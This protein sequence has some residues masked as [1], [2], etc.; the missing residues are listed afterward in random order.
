MFLCFIYTADA[1]YWKVFA[2][3]A[4]LTAVTVEGVQMYF[5]HKIPT[6]W[7]RKNLNGKSPERS[8][9]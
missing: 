2:F 3:S 9:A 5:P 1:V 6:I 4:I 7:G 8:E